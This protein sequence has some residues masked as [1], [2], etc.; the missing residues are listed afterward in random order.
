M[1][2][3]PMDSDVFPQ[4]HGVGEILATDLTLKESMQMT[5]LVS[6]I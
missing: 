6:F 1:L 5:R 2:T 4:R 3:F